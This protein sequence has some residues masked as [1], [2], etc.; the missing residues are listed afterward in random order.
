[1]FEDD[2]VEYMRRD[3]EPS[4]GEL[5]LGN[6]EADILVCRKRYTSTSCHRVHSS[7]DGTLRGRRHKHHQKLHY[8]VPPGLL[9]ESSRP[10]EEQGHCHLP[11]NVYRIERIDAAGEYYGGSFMAPLIACS[12]WCYLYKR[13]GRC[14]RI[15]WPKCLLRPP[16]GS[17]YRQPDPGGRCHQIPV[18]VPK[19][20][21]RNRKLFQ[22]TADYLP[23]T[24]YERPAHFRP[25]PPCTAS[26]IG[27]LRHLLL[28]RHHD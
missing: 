10:V 26:H 19:S 4:T 7:S 11:A 3:L 16:S 22:Y 24:A 14:C 9:V 18:Y 12:A 25:A 6:F 15:L 27:Q 13:S 28:R 23:L 1:M 17:R 2:P 5:N 20:S 21:R 8:L